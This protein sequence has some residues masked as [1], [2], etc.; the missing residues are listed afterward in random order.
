[1]ITPDKD[2]CAHPVA[3]SK[4]TQPIDQIS[5]DPRLPLFSLLITSGAMYIGVPASELT[6][7]R[8]SAAFV[9]VCL[10]ARVR[11]I[12]LFPLA[13]I[14]AAPKSTSLRCALSVRRISGVSLARLDT[15]CLA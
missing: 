3:I 4:I 15:H 7:A 9:R 12:V 8:G 11:A 1:M 13:M 10:A 6:A 5:D 14:L 2:H